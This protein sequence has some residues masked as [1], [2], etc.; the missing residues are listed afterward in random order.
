[1]KAFVIHEVMERAESEI[2]RANTSM[3]VSIAGEWSFTVVN[4][5]SFEV[6][7]PDLFIEFFYVAA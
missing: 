5:E 1:M 2:A 3:E 6:L 7:Q 4:M